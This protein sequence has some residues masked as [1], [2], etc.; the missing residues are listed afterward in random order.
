V[1]PSAAVAYP[2]RFDA[3][4]QDE[5]HRFLPLVKWL[6]AFPHYVVLF[7]LGIGA[8]LAIIASWFA[9]LIT[10]TY[11][12]GL[13]DF[14][15]GVFRWSYRVTGYVYLLTDEYPPFSLDEEPGYPVRVEIDYPEHV[16]RWRP[17]VAWLLAIPYLIVAGILAYL[18]AIVA[19]I[20][21]FV[22]LFTRELPRGM[23]NLIAYPLRWQLRGNAYAL[24][25]VTRYPPFSWD[26]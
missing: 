21:V 7:F 10:G 11:P 26:E 14:V 2:A 20:G 4:R 18:A 24:W 17:L 1:P 12:R 8:L 6:L 25:M 16:E 22:I 19:L 15:R 13:F 5:Y 3:R 9:V 23:F